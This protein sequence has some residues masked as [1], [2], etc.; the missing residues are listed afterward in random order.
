MVVHSTKNASPHHCPNVWKCTFLST[1]TDHIFNKSVIKWQVHRL[2]SQDSKNG[3][4]KNPRKYLHG[5]QGIKKKEQHQKNTFMW[6]PLRSPRWKKNRGTERAPTSSTTPEATQPRGQ[7]YLWAGAL[8]ACFNECCCLPVLGHLVPLLIQ[9]KG[10]TE[11]VSHGCWGGSSWCLVML[12]QFS[13]AA[14]AL[15]Y[16]HIPTGKAPEMPCKWQQSPLE[17]INLLMAVDIARDS[18]LSVPSLTVPPSMC[19][20]WRWGF[21]HRYLAHFWVDVPAMLWWPGHLW[22]WLPGWT[23]QV[24]Q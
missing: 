8:L 5:P 19:L 10:C 16:L 2:G 15:L 18:C 12:E 13:W 7:W 22:H 3:R 9:I 4:R 24:T 17:I 20:D 11:A 6:G 1:S 21:M 23:T 14:E